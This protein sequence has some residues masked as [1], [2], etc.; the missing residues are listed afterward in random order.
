MY[1]RQVKVINATGLHARPAAEFVK[2]AKQ[3]SSAIEI[4]REGSGQGVNAKS[5][6]RLLSEAVTQGTTVEISAE[7][8]DEQEAVDRLAALIESGFGE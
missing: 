4:R 1:S 2:T 3:F 6:A 7:G 8:P 5:I